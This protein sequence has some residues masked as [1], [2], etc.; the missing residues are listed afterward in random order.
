MSLEAIL[1]KIE[2]DAREKAQQI[3]ESA[4]K[5]KKEALHVVKAR[6]KD[7]HHR[8]TDR[9]KH[10]VEARSRRMKHHIRRETEKALL[11]HRRKIV[12][13]AINEAVKQISEAPDYLKMIEVLLRGCDFKG[14]VEVVICEKDS[15][16]V[17]GDFLREISTEEVSFVCSKTR[18]ND[19]G[20]VIMR[21]GD[22]SLNATLSMLAELNHDEMVMELSKLLP[23]E[24]RG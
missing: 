1:A 15:E 3:I 22:I 21:S 4:E 24:G 13:G 18:H 11:S 8:D 17:T 20:G 10:R 14:E 9:V 16:R 19:H 6:I 7:H 23:L 2:N 5:E 12:D